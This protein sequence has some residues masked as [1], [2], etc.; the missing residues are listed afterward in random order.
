M[1]P[2]HI[3]VTAP[4]GR[5]TPIH[6]NDGSDPES[7]TLM[8]VEHGTIARVK[9]SADVRRAIARGDLIAVDGDGAHTT[10][11]EKASAPKAMQAF[12]IE[13]GAELELEKIVLARHT[14]RP[15][16]RLTSR[17]DVAT[18]DATRGPERTFDTSDAKPKKE[19]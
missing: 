7:P 15:P 4:E 9:Y 5:K 19:R 13:T 18:T 3:T 8:F 14:R 11:L 1:P 17:A 6:P 16:G 12:D 2:T 10:D